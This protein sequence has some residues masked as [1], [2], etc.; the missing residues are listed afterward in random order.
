L[1]VYLELEEYVLA[2]DLL[3]DRSPGCND[4]GQEVFEFAEGEV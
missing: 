3:D 2:I 1:G 4:I